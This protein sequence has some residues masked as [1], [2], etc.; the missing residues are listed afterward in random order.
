[1]ALLPKADGRRRSGRGGGFVL[2]L[3]L[4]LLWIYVNFP[5]LS[6]LF[7]PPAGGRIPKSFVKGKKE[8][9]RQFANRAINPF[10]GKEGWVGCLNEHLMRRFS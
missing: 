6:I 8:E 7:F 1:M 5:S 2:H 9:R 4:A 10:K 3:D